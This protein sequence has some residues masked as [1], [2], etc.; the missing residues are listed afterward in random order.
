MAVD[1][2]VVLHSLRV[3]SALA[4]NDPIESKLFNNSNMNQ[5]FELVFTLIANHAGS[6]SISPTFAYRHFTQIRLLVSTPS[7]AW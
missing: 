3:I 5:T 1:M 6:M 4:V 7:P 2:G